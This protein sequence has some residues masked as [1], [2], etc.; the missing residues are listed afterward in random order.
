MSPLTLDANTAITLAVFAYVSTLLPLLAAGE[1]LLSS[2]LWGFGVP[3]TLAFCWAILT[4][5]LA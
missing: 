5:L 3:I 1:S 4:I 2:F